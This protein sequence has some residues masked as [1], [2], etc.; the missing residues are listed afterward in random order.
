M[1]GPPGRPATGMP[2]PW[3]WETVGLG[4][5]SPMRSILCSCIYWLITWGLLATTVHGQQTEQATVIKASAVLQQTMAEATTS[6]PA[7]LLRDA[8]GIAIVP[9]VLKGSFIVGARHGKG[10][11]LVRDE[12]QRWGAPVFVSLT[13][14]NVGWQVGVQSSDVILVFKTRKSIEGLLSG[15]LTLGADASAA[16]GPV[17][18]EASAAT[19]GRLQAEI[20]SYSRSRGL[21]AGVSIDGSVINVDSAANAIYYQARAPGET[22]FVPAEAVQLVE[23]VTVSTG[24][25]PVA[26]APDGAVGVRPPLALPNAVDEAS[27]VRDELARS[28]SRLFQL[29]D[30]RWQDYLTLPAE[31]FRGQGHPSSQVLVQC[32]RRYE[33]VKGDARYAPLT[34]R[35]EFQSTSAQ[36][37]QYTQLLSSQPAPL[38]L[39]APPPAVNP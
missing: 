32:Q 26:A 39:P 1:P 27:R 7:V 12:N 10:V 34:S 9:D 31:I 5:G 14:G 6:I 35:P 15:K 37:S 11:L 20:Y 8:H 2:I 16:A 36:L 38:S 21:F 24:T 3:D 18:R 4:K 23:Q 22:A 33:A 28:A 13:G 19:D 17:G 30:A 29:L 25:I